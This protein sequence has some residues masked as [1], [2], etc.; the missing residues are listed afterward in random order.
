MLRFYLALTIFPFNSIKYNLVSFTLSLGLLM[1]K[2]IYWPSVRQFTI[3]R[4]EVS[5]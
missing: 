4:K 3:R 5:E 1:L 2:N